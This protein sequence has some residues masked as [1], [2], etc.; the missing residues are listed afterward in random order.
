[1]TP[2]LE[3]A[4]AAACSTSR[5]TPAVLCCRCLLTADK[6]G[7]T[8]RPAAG[9]S[10]NLQAMQQPAGMA[11]MA[12]GMM[13]AAAGGGV[14]PGQQPTPQQM[15]QLM[16]TQAAI[17]AQ[18][19][20][21]APGRAP[22]PGAAGLPV[23]LP[24]D[25]HAALHNAKVPSAPCFATGAGDV[26]SYTRTLVSCADLTFCASYSH[27]VHVLHCMISAEEPRPLINGPPPPTHPPPQPPPPFP[28]SNVG[29]HHSHGANA[30]WPDDGAADATAR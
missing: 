19:A 24:L 16:Q 17:H 6:P 22:S 11:G 29:D 18:F 13:A 3:L 5:L 21:T 14:R 25:R 1:M 30:E 9:S 8:G 15:Q 20:A 12:P 2:A 7:A 26:A 27:H 4:A 28:P 10:S 23:S